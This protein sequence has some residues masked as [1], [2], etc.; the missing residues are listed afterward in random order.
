[1][2]IIKLLC[3]FIILALSGQVIAQDN[4]VLSK[5]SDTIFTARFILEKRKLFSIPEINNDTTEFVFRSWK[6]NSMLE[7]KKKDSLVSGSVTYFVLDAWEGSKEVF[8][9]QYVLDLKE[10]VNTYKFIT[11]SAAVNLPSDKYI[12]GWQLG[13]DGIT[14]TF[15]K[16]DGNAYSFKKYWTPSSQH[17]LS[18]AIAIEKFHEDLYTIIGDKYYKDFDSVNPFLNYKYPGEAYTIMKVVTAKE[19]RKYKKKHKKLYGN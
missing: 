2:P 9:K 14:Y 6:P 3:T 7:I 17:G 5:D 13:F 12:S 4:I 10:A 1:M 16:K 8:A 15:E 18:E 19:Y 11:N